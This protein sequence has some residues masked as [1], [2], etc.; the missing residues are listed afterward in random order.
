MQTTRSGCSDILEPLFQY[1]ALDYLVSSAKTRTCCSSPMPQR[2]TRLSS[3]WLKPEAFRRTILR[4]SDLDVA[5][6]FAAAQK[7]SLRV[8]QKA[9]EEE[10]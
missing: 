1:T 2:G 4:K 6:A 5:H 3:S 8:V 10:S 9:A 7:Q